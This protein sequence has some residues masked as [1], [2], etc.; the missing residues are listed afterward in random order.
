M[1]TTATGLLFAHVVDPKQRTGAVESFGYKQLLF[2]PF[3]G[4]G[5]VTAMSM[6][7]IVLFGLP[8][9]MVICAMVSFAWLAF[10]VLALHKHP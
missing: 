7:M 5:I 1:G 4:G 2:E 3:M 9:F 10:G 8:Q 6:P